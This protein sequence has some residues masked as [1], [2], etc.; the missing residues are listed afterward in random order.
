MSLALNTLWGRH[1]ST[2]PWTAVFLSPRFMAGGPPW[3]VWSWLNGNSLSHPN[4]SKTGSASFTEAHHIN[5]SR[6]ECPQGL[7]YLFP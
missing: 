2:V 7:L 4:Y 6:A 1:K 3:V 5:Q